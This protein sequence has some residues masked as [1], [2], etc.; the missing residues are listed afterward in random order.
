MSYPQVVAGGPDA[1]TIHYARNDKVL[2]SPM[3]ASHVCRLHPVH[4]SQSV[5]A[6]L[7]LAAS[8]SM[9]E[10]LARCKFAALYI[11]ICSSLSVIAR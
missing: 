5:L 1:C 2:L 8:V 9:Q 3:C 7:S 4:A 10:R 6:V 11:E